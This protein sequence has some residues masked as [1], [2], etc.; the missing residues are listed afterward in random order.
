MEQ[1]NIPLCRA[2]HSSSPR[3][4][5]RFLV[6]ISCIEHTLR[7]GHMVVLQARETRELYLPVMQMLLGGLLHEWSSQILRRARQGDE[8]ALGSQRYLISLFHLSDF[9]M[10]QLW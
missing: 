3:D 5:E 1:G 2:N 4:P 8:A 9:P 6:G 10:D 7:R